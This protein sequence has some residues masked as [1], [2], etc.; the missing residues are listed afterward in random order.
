[1]QNK[2]LFQRHLE[3]GAALGVAGSPH[4]HALR[5]LREDEPHQKGKGLFVFVF[6]TNGLK[7][8]SARISFQ[9]C[10]RGLVSNLSAN[11]RIRRSCKI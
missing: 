5:T 8:L 2:G 6:I 3:Q 1:M 11:R 9:R 7:Q 10:F 4:H